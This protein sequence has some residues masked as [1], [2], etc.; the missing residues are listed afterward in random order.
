MSLRK[1]VLDIAEQMSDLADDLEKD[2][3]RPVVD[4]FDLF[5]KMLMDAVAKDIKEN[6]HES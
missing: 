6:N 3:I 1:A 5:A 2:N 4:Q